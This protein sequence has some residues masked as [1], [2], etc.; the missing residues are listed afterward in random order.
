MPRNT[1]HAFFMLYAI[2]N[3]WNFDLK[4]GI[5]KAYFITEFD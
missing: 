1:K 3:F 4:V 5:R 2:W